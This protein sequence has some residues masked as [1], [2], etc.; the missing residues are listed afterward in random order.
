[1]NFFDQLLER[2]QALPGVESAGVTNILPLGVGNGV[3]KMF[4]VEGHPL[5]T[6]LEQV[7]V[8]GMALV[9]P[10]YFNTLGIP[11]HRGRGFFV[12]P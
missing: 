12:R 7:P 1:L 2:T 4:S 11:L 8:V 3:G 9:S 10:N 5:A 6:S